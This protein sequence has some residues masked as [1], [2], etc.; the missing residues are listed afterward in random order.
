MSDDAPIRIIDDTSLPGVRQG[1]AWQILLVDDLKDI[2]DL[3]SLVLAEV[4]VC[5]RPLTLH[6]TYSYQGAVDYL[7]A[8]DHRQFALALI[9]VVMETDDAGLRLVEHIRDRLGNRTMRV[10]LRTGQPGQEQEDEISNTY[11]IDGYRL[12]TDLSVGQLIALV[13]TQV[14]SFARATAAET[15]AATVTARCAAQIRWLTRR[16][17]LL[18]ELLRTASPLAGNLLTLAPTNPSPPVTFVIQSLL[19]AAVALVPSVQVRPHDRHHRAGMGTVGDIARFI[20]AL[21]WARC[22]RGATA[23][24]LTCRPEGLLAVRLLHLTVGDPGHALPDLTAG[25]LPPLDDGGPW[26]ALLLALAEAL[27]ATVGR[28]P[29]GAFG[30]TITLEA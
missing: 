28:L 26:E 30:A 23:Q 17:R 24:E 20:A 4:T 29:D 3:S 12:K 14:R 15:Q 10:V 22:A 13:I 19:S 18:T 11:D 16:D 8:H 2:H 1:P 9:D 6:Y 5:G 21:A 27:G 25:P 7:A